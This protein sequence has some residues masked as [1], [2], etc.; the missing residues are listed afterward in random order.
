MRGLATSP[1]CSKTKAQTDHSL[2]YHLIKVELSITTKDKSWRTQEHIS[3]LECMCGANL[4][5]TESVQQAP[6]K[7]HS[8][9]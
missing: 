2:T 9:S 5:K 7:M 1:I 3:T 4:F 6:D 8:L